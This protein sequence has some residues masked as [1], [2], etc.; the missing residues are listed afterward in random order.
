MR[1]GP[2]RPTAPRSWPSIDTGATTTAHDDSGSKPCSLPMA[3]ER[4]R[5]STSRRSVTT[6]SC[7]SRMREHG[8]HRLDGLERLGQAGGPPTKTWSASM[9]P[10]SVTEG[11]PCRGHHDGRPAWSRSAAR[12]TAAVSVRPTRCVASCAPARASTSSET[13]PSSSMVRF[14]TAPSERTTTSSTCCG[15]R[16]TSW[17][18]RMVA[19]SC[20]GPTTTAA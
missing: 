20:E 10:S 15:E 17:T 4:P 18:A 9:A 8:A 16:P 5:P 6:T 14:S 13:S 3:T 11:G 1:V 2:R 7:C 19:V 12:T